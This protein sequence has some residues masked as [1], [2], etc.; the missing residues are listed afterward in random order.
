MIRE[1]SQDGSQLTLGPKTLLVGLGEFS[2]VFSCAFH[3]FIP[4]Q[5]LG[6]PFTP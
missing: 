6:P 4:R 2:T 3:S 1:N 5:I